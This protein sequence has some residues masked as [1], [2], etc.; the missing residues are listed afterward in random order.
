VATEILLNHYDQQR[1]RL[2]FQKSWKDKMKSKVEHRKKGTKPPFF[3]N[4]G[5]QNEGDNGAKI[6]AIT[7][8]MLGLW[9]R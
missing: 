1:G 2:T 9:K 7:Y 8:L 3:R 6:K 5:A 4:Q